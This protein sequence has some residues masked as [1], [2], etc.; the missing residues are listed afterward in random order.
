V[1]LSR[2]GGVTLVLSAL[3]LGDLLTA[4]PAL[5][6]VRRAV[7]GPLVLA[8]PAPLHALVEQL[9]EVD[10][11][12]PARALEPLPF[13]RPDVAVDL[14]GSGPESHRVLLAT[15][16]GRLVAFASAEAGVDGPQWRTDEH[17]V[18]RWCRLVEFGLGASADP[19]D[20]GIRV[21]AQSGLAG[22]VVIHP[23]AAS[24]SRRWPVDRFAAVAESLRLAGERV[25]VTGSTAE[26]AL[27]ESIADAAG[28]PPRDVLA[29]RT[30]V[31]QLAAAVAAADVVVSG[32]TGVAHLAVALGRPSVTL[33]GPVPPAL[34]G[35]PP[36]PQH[37]VLWH[38]SY[39]SPGDP[40]AVTPDPALLRITVPEVLTAVTHARDAAPMTSVA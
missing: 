24:G 34:W 40:H 29:G 21:S 38:G 37:V 19:D 32:D 33:S 5:R 13:E 2:A 8:T 3:G 27:A 23:G 20:L 15:R 31:V 9:D 1:A 12:L 4:L 26:R 22:A 18:R 14:H 10:A 39:D 36:R 35:P 30:D 17:V 16:P 11:A 25:V 28:L 7:S 6:A